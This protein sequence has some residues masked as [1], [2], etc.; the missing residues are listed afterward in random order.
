MA[1]IKSISDIASKWARVT[2]ARTEDYEKG[3]RSP[4]RDWASETAGAEARYGEGVQTAI[5]EGRFARGVADAG[6]GKWQAKAVSKGVPR[7]GPGVREA[8][9]DYEKGFGPF[10]NVI[11]G[12]TLPPRYPKGDPRNIE[13]VAT[14]ASALHDAKV[15]A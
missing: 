6:S 13:R 12:V 14:I 15:G 3:V 2:P 9:P 5:A 1:A 4:R 11:E 8:Q 10:R 7:W